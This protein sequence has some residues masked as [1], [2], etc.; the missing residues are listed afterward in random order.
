MI[1]LGYALSSEEFSPAELISFAHTAEAV[2]FDFAMISDHFHPWTES[3][4][5]PD[6]SCPHTEAI[7]KPTSQTLHPIDNA[8]WA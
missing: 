5:R 3:H 2:G 6:V 7:A 1:E 4:E 8:F